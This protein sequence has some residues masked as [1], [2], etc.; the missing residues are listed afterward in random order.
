[1]SALYQNFISFSNQQNF[2]MLICPTP[3]TFTLPSSKSSQIWPS[4]VPSHDVADETRT[5]VPSLLTENAASRGKISRL[6]ASK[7][8]SF[9]TRSLQL[10]KLLPRKDAFAIPAVGKFCSHRSL[11][12]RAKLLRRVG[13][14][15]LFQPIVL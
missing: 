7:S 6:I 4:A 14:K 12:R 1:M 10:T 8:D 15:N 2:R 13:G 11:G 9:S 3:S 5:Q